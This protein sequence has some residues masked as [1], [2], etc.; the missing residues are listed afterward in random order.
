MTQMSDPHT[1]V[2]TAAQANCA[3]SWVRSRPRGLAWALHGAG[4][5]KG[6]VC[7]LMFASCVIP[8]SLSVDTTDAGANAAPSITSV[9]ADGVELPEYAKV[10]FER[11][12]GTLNLVLYDTDLDD[13]L[14]A[15]AF[16]DYKSTD[17]TPAR[18]NCQTAG[19]TVQRSCT[20]D[21]AGLCQAADVG[22]DDLIM[23]LLVFDRQVLDTGAPLYQAMPPGG[24]STSR[25][26]FLVCQEPST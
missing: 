11:G 13:V 14:F 18:S 24:L 9:R 6:L 5:A 17:P 1:D 8:P 16:V 12:A 7:L 19:A 2:L 26:Y 23:Q 3:T 15:K 22:N 21:L 4:V 25:T 20:L 10:N